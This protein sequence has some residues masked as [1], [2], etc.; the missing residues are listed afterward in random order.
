MRQSG[1][2][3]IGLDRATLL[4]FIVLEWRLLVN[5]YRISMQEIHISMQER[6]F[7]LL[8]ERRFQVIFS[9]RFIVRE[10]WKEYGQPNGD[11]R[12]FIPTDQNTVVAL[13]FCLVHPLMLKWKTMKLTKEVD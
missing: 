9:K 2:E 11:A 10:I 7:S 5:L 1:L 8:H 12:W 4:F 13:S 3:K 6:V